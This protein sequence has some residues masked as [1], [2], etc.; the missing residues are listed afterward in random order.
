MSDLVLASRTLDYGLE[1]LNQYA[2]RIY[3]C[4]QQPTTYTE[5]TST[6]ALGMKD[7][8]VGLVFGSPADATPDGRQV[9]TAEVIDGEISTAGTVAAWAAVDS[10]NSRLLATGILTGGMA[11]RVGQGFKLGILT[12]RATSS[13]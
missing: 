9:S 4:T 7:L 6:Y 13:P 12:V 5:A 10:V 3:V 8:G 1:E 2:D 11:V